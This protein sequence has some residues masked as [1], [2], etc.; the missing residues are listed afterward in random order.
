MP[1]KWHLI[2]DANPPDIAP[3]SRLAQENVKVK[4]EFD[5]S[6][7]EDELGPQALKIPLSGELMENGYPPR[8]FRGSV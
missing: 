3:A 8:V 6:E 7:S 5:D 2:G 4:G 1:S